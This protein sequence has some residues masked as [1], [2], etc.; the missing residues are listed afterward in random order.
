MRT[1]SSLFFYTFYKITV[2]ICSPNNGSL[3]KSVTKWHLKRINWAKSCE[4]MAG[5][6]R[7]AKA[8]STCAFVQSDQGLRCPLTVSWHYRLYQWRAMSGWDFAH[9][10][11]ETVRRYIFA[12]RGSNTSVTYSDFKR[13]NLLLHIKMRAISKR[14]LQGTQRIMIRS[15]WCRGMSLVCYRCGPV[16]IPASGMWQDSG[17]SPIVSVSHGLLRFPSPRLTTKRQ[18]PRFD[19]ASHLENMPI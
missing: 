9:T 4:N 2:C 14:Y 7:K 15:G 6:I 19:N 11:D 10:L 5:H 13:V 8:R 17:R 3:N 16:S 1:R 12:R 18:H